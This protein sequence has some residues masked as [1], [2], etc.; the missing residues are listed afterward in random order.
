MAS[1]TSNRHN[2]KLVVNNVEAPVEAQTNL[3]TKQ[4]NLPFD[5]QNQIAIIPEPFFS[6]TLLSLLVQEHRPRWFIDIRRSPRLDLIAGS[7]SQAF[8]TFRSL[9]I[10]YIALASLST[11]SNLISDDLLW[12]FTPLQQHLRE[13]GSSQGPYF[14]I[15]EDNA[16]IVEFYSQVER[17]F[18]SCLSDNENIEFLEY[19]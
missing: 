3:A 12:W 2:L 18:D 6:E 8:E 10:C 16:D 13:I 7:R 9:D 14:L 11:S 17:I 19:N 15:T 4:L 1:Q 5:N